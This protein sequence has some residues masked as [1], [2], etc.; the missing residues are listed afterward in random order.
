[1]SDAERN[2]QMV[3]HFNAAYSV[4]ADVIVTKDDGRQIATKTRSPAWILNERAVILV[5]GISGS[6]L[7]ERVRPVDK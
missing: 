5:K 1:M 7:L 4:G 6:Y 3:Y 2:D